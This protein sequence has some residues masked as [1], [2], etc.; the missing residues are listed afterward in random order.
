M[1]WASKQIDIS[2]NV[3]NKRTNKKGKRGLPG[4]PGGPP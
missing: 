3:E 4:L 2:L 1:R